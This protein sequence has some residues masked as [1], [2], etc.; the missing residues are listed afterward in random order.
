ME[1]IPLVYRG[2][3]GD[4]W[5]VIRNGSDNV[6][7]ERFTLLALEEKSCLILWTPT[8]LHDGLNNS[9]SPKVSLAEID[10][11]LD[12]DEVVVFGTLSAAAAMLH[13]NASNGKI[14]LHTPNNCSLK[15]DW[16]LPSPKMATVEQALKAMPRL[17][18]A[19]SEEPYNINVDK[20]IT[21]THMNAVSLKRA[22]ELADVK[23]SC[24]GRNGRNGTPSK[25]ST[26]DKLKQVKQ[27]KKKKSIKKRSRDEV[28]DEEIFDTNG[29]DL[30]LYDDNAIDDER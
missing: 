11:Y 26:A 21:S 16:P 13:C 19:L 6:Q 9:A 5:N 24:I 7:I 28:N 14:L 8:T 25:D 27:Q 12:V 4:A 23:E 1:A 17:A 18:K 20:K 3:I 15:N 29:S 22:A 2:S 10:E 30:P